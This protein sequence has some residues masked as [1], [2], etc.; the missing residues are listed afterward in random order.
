M[1]VRVAEG[2]VKMGQGEGWQR[3]PDDSAVYSF[4]MIRFGEQLQLMNRRVVKCQILG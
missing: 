4:H 1:K 3:T 2:W